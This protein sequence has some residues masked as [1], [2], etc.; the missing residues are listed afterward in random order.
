[1]WDYQKNERS[2]SYVYENNRRNSCDA[3]STLF[4]AKKEWI[5]WRSLEGSTSLR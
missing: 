3:R 4:Q 2:K 1:M 5:Q